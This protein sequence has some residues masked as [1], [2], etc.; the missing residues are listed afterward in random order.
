VASPPDGVPPDE[1][2]WDRRHKR[3]VLWHSKAGRWLTH[4]DAGWAPLDADEGSDATPGG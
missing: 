2:I 4:T 1:P 3:Y